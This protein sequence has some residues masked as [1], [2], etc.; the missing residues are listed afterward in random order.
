MVIHRWSV[1]KVLLFIFGQKR[2]VCLLFL[3]HVMNNPGQ[4]GLF[5]ALC[6]SEFQKIYDCLDIK[7]IERGE[8]F[9]QDMM[10]DVVKELEQKGQR[11][12]ETVFC[13]VFI[14]NHPITCSTDQ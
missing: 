12:C 9:Y 6:T 14:S 13:L 10:T 5:P 3:L 2:Q 4:S 7:I 8:S 11:P 1:K